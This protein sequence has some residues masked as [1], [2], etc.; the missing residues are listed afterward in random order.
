MD[1]LATQN[2]APNVILTDRLTMRLPE[3]SDF[4]DM[5]QLW[6][7]PDVVR[8]IGGRTSTDDE[9][10]Q[11][12]LRYR[13]LWALVGYGYWTIRETKTG[14]FVGEMGFA[15]WHRAGLPQLKGVPE[16]GWVLTSAM[17]GKGYA[18]EALN[19][20]LQW[21]DR[22]ITPRTSACIIAPENR[23][24][25]RLAEQC[26]YREVSRTAHR[27]TDTLVMVRDHLPRGHDCGAD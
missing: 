4:A 10:W 5:V 9:V 17:Q 15:D 12:L 16:G 24:S 20:A 7:D 2:E 6:S 23:R 25:L 21:L 11:R 3:V 27:Q 8:Y 18:R 26:G 14:D 22:S 13:G 1:A 19:A